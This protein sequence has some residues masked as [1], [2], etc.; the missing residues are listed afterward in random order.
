MWPITSKEDFNSFFPCQI[1][2]LVNLEIEQS[3]CLLERTGVLLCAISRSQFV[4]VEVLVVEN[5]APSPFG[6]IHIIVHIIATTWQLATG[7][8]G[9]RSKPSHK[10]ED[11]K[12]SN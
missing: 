11:C 7:R 9:F 2:V 3:K 8:L 1:L 5:D 6:V 10:K 12:Y 4:V